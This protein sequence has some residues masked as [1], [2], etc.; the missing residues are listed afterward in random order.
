[1]N[2]QPDVVAAVE[3]LCETALRL[4][5]G[6]PHEATVRGIHDRLEGPLRVAIAGRVKAG[7]ST[8]LNALVGE[9]LAATDAGECTH[10]VTS[11]RHAPGYEVVA[12]LR[13]G[14]QRPLTFRRDS[15]VLDVDLG[16]LAADDIAHLDVGWPAKVLRDMTLIDT[17]GLASLNDENSRRTRD[18]LDHDATNPASADAV[19][20][21]MRHLH[22]SDADFLGGFMDRTVAGASPVNALAVLSRADEIG[23]CRADAMESAGRIA[24]RYSG[25]PAVSTLVADVIPVAGLLAETGLTLTQ[26][27][28][29]ALAQLAAMP[30]D[31][32]MLLTLSVDDFCDVALSPLTAEIRRDLLARLG[33]FGVRRALALL[34]DPDAGGPTAG[35]LSRELVEVSGLSELRRAIAEQFLPRARLLKARSALLALRGVAASLAADG[36]PRGRRVRQR[37]RPSRRRCD[38]VRD[39]AGRPPGDVRCGQRAA[40]RCRRRRACVGRTGSGHRLRPPRHDAGRA[41][42]GGPRRVDQVAGAQQRSTRK[43]PRRH[44]RRHDGPPV[45]RALR[46]GLRP[47]SGGVGGGAGDDAERLDAVLPAIS[48]RT[49]RRR[50]DRTGCR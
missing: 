37:T 44:R 50:R 30:A 7:K 12:E 20:Y 23:A 29:G 17:P 16:G 8:L 19:I 25:D 40:V 11:F 15:G 21:L 22:R 48:R 43:L 6:G 32:Q 18:F 14:T 4:T 9:R 41:P 38:R 3:A 13:D 47:W 42:S 24:R 26:S 28:Y 49:V 39:P 45:R 27:E 10:V 36:S 1:M 31:E 33:I 34:S 46:L 5:A 2:A 35:E